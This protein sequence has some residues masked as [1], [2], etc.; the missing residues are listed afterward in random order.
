MRNC[1]PS[2]KNFAPLTEMVGI[3]L[4]VDAMPASTASCESKLCM[5]MVLSQKLMR[6]LFMDVDN[7]QSA[8]KNVIE[9]NAS[10]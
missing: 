7:V 2:A 9:W 5:V 3:A 6:I 4:T 1:W 10:N 8:M